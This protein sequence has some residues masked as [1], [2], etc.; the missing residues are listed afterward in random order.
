MT[1]LILIKKFDLV[2]DINQSI[3]TIFLDDINKDV[4]ALHHILTQR[5][6]RSSGTVA[7]HHLH[8]ITLRCS[9][10]LAI[11]ILTPLVEDLIA[12]RTV[13]GGTIFQTQNPR[14]MPPKASMQSQVHAINKTIRVLC[15]VLGTFGSQLIVR[16]EEQRNRTVLHMLSETE[17]T[18][19]AIKCIVNTV[20]GKSDLD[21]EIL[22]ALLTKEAT[23]GKNR[24][25]TALDVANEGNNYRE[26]KM[27]QECEALC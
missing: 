10:S 6:Y 27:L 12:Y 25:V 14:Y 7:C 4:T 21:R 1:H 5:S 15:G 3:A 13:V 22:H 20:K 11:N 26:A 17:G 19:P 18:Y 8:K 23:Y 2:A 24:R 16:N 9:E